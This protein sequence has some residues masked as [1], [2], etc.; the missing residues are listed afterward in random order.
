MARAGCQMFCPPAT[1]KQTCST[2]SIRS[3]NFIENATVREMGLLRFVPSS[4]HLI[5]GESGQVFKRGRM[6]FGDI[7]V[8]RTEIMF[9]GNFLRGIGRSEERRVGKECRS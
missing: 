2:S 1:K 5:D 9:G 8:P 3:K 4:K 6:L 7:F